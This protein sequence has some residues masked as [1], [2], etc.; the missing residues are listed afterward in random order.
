MAEAALNYILTCL[1][2]EQQRQLRI[3]FKAA[4]MKVTGLQEAELPDKW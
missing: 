3:R 4:A 1:S 2:T